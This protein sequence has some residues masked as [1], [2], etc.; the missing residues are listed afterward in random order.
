MKKL[1]LLAAILLLFGL[2][3]GFTDAAFDVSGSA[4]ATFG[5]DLDNEAAGFENDLDASYIVW[6]IPQETVA[7]DAESGWYGWIEFADFGVGWDNDDESDYYWYADA[8]PYDDKADVD[9][10]DTEW[11]P[12]LYVKLPDVTAKVTNGPIYVQV[13][14][15]PSFDNDHVTVVEDDEDDDWFA[16]I[17]QTERIDWD[18]SDAVNGGITIG[19][20][21]DAFGV[22]VYVADNDGYGDATD[23]SDD[24]LLGANVTVSMSGIDVSA[25]VAK[26]MNV[27][28][29]DL[30]AGADVSYTADLGMGSLVPYVGFEYYMSD[31][32]D[33]AVWEM[34]AGADLTFT[35]DNV[36]GLA[37]YMSDFDDSIDFEVTFTEDGEA[38][39]VPALGVEVFFGGYDVF[40]AYD[41][42]VDVSYMIDAIKPFAGVTYGYDETIVPDDTSFT[43]NAGVEWTGL[44]NTTVTLEWSSGNLMLDPI[45]K[46]V[47]ELTAEVA[48]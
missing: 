5:Y 25:D 2:T 21:T 48:M 27:A 13:Y 38:G 6:L 31:T 40:A 10:A 7:T 41:L 24:W 30:Y 23:G 3:A 39:F 19:Y 17:D 12:H 37:F 11:S 28:E 18:W 36:F 32:V 14:G 47:I 20:D 33:P 45:E 34:A 22:A 35:N 1:A 44:P 46:G 9:P 4:S 43:A 42:G 26:A 16:Q 15:A 29:N 8:D